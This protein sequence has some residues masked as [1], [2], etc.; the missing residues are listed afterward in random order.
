M[1]RRIVDR[2]DIEL[3][4]SLS[5][6][7]DFCAVTDNIEHIGIFGSQLSTGGT[8]PGIDEVTGGDRRT[9]GEF[10][11]AAEPEGI[12]RFALRIGGL[13][14]AVFGKKIRFKVC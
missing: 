12:D 8:V 11:S 13:R 14:F 2:G 10:D 3:F 9:I 7:F 4:G 1:K 5:I 6:C